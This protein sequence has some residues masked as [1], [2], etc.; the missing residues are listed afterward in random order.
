MSNQEDDVIE[1][2]F[3]SPIQLTM[4]KFREA[5]VTGFTFLMTPFIWIRDIVDSTPTDSNNK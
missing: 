5:L 3:Q 1:Q 4:L 2:N